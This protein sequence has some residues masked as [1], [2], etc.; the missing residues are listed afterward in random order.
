MA[1]KEKILNEDDFLVSTT[2]KQG[3]ITYANFGFADMAEYS[4]SDL[5]GKPHNIVRHPDMPRCIFKAVWQKLLNKEPVV[6]YVKNFTSDKES[7]YWVKAFMFPVVE[8][9]DI[10]YITSYRTKPSRFAIEQISA[11]YSQ[12]LDYE[13]GHGM[14][15]ALKL[16]NGFLED[17]GLTYEELVNRLNANK[18]VLNSTLL[19]IDR[20]KFK[21]DHIAFKSHIVSQVERGTKDIE[22][23]GSCC[24]AFGK[25]LDTYKNEP[26]SRDR[27]F[28]T[29]KKLHDGVHADLKKMT[30]VDASQR[31]SI[32]HEVSLDTVKLFGAL[33]ELVDNFAK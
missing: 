32:S 29:I 24:C 26:F 6:A 7:F 4:V 3:N 17:R 11:V 2:D 16:F 10:A 33:D 18:Q 22:V 5:V 25:A 12:L 19:N 27:L 15:S 8:N 31:N 14:D 30:T 1:E 28:S 9:G 13:R 21:I 23:V 20:K